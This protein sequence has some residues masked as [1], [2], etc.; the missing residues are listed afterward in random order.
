MGWEGDVAP[1]VRHRSQVYCQLEKGDYRSLVIGSFVAGQL[2]NGGQGECF[3][4]SRSHGKSSW[5]VI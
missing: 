2:D 3:D 4:V 5:L 1:H